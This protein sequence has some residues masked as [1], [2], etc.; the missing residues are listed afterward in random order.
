MPDERNAVGWCRRLVAAIVWGD[1]GSVANITN[2]SYPV[3]TRG[4]LHSVSSTLTTEH[5]KHA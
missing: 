5:E 3:V 1:T 2:I 4:A